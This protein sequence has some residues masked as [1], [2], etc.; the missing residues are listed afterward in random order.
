MKIETD[1]PT[2]EF[3]LSFDD[4]KVTI[5]LE[6][7]FSDNAEDFIDVPAFVELASR[8]ILASMQG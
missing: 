4:E 5:T 2:A 6:Y 7:H 3:E 8:E 1:N